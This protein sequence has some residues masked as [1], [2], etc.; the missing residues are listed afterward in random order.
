M[1]PHPARRY[2]LTVVR[3]VNRRVH[4]GPV[5][6]AGEAAD[7]FD[8]KRWWVFRDGDGLVV[9]KGGRGGAGRETPEAE[10]RREI[11]GV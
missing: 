3:P 4:V 10:S 8:E 2:G 7:P 5:E 11:D 9:V 6:F 1:H